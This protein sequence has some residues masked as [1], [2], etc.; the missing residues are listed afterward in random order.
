MPIKEKSNRDGQFTSYKDVRS[1][2]KFLICLFK[3]IF[4]FYIRT[5]VSHVVLDICTNFKEGAQSLEVCYIS[6]SDV[7]YNFILSV[8]A[9]AHPMRS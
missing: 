2:P 7:F 8:E 6:S 4:A 1:S 3:L 9:Y 5:S